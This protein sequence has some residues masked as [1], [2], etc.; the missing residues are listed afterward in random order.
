MDGLGKIIEKIRSESEHHC[1]Q[2]IA[3]AQGK[4]ADIA[5]QTAEQ[6]EKEAAAAEEKSDE[7][8]KAVVYRALA[9][10]E[11]QKKQAQLKAKIT[12]INAAIDEAKESFEKLPAEQYFAA[13][14]LLAKANAQP[15]MGIMQLSQ[16]DLARVP[17]GFEEKLK[18]ITLSRTPAGIANGFILIY[19]DIEINCTVDALVNE[20][21]DELTEKVNSM[22][23]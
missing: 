14:L 7:A 8:A 23:F 18:N 6:I 12:A 2:A 21:R 3:M 15:G 9:S 22:V 1:A 13:L 20:K 16:T 4:A 19:G 5:G 10:V 11:Q 17:A